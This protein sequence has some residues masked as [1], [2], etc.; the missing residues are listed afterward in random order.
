MIILTGN[1]M[2]NNSHIGNGFI[3]ILYYKYKSENIYGRIE[4]IYSDIIKNCKSKLILDIKNIDEY[5][6]ICYNEPVYYGLMLADAKEKHIIPDCS[7]LSNAIMQ[8]NCHDWEEDYFSYDLSNRAKIF[9][10]MLE[11]SKGYEKD[12]KY[13]ELQLIDSKALY[14]DTDRI[15][16]KDRIEKNIIIDTEIAKY[17]D[18]IKSIMNKI[19][20]QFSINLSNFGPYYDR[21][22]DTMKSKVPNYPHFKEV[23]SYWYL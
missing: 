8:L 19:I 18:T 14:I 23:F 16:I 13:L 10:K 9:K 5:D 1:N 7:R 2:N 12:C 6:K 4:E 22:Y 11:I 20:G 3:D 15:T 17:N 21:V